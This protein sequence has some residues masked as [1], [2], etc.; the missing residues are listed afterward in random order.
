MPKQTRNRLA[1]VLFHL[2]GVLVTLACLLP[3]YWVVVASLRA[4]GLPPA[5]GIEWWPAAAHW[6][7]YAELFRSLPMARYLLNSLI[8]VLSAVPLT[9]LVA[10]LAGFGLSQLGNLWRRR[11]VAVS[12]ALLLVPG[13]A[14]WTLR[15]YVLNALGLIDSLG[16]LIVPALAGGSPLFI[17]LFYW[18]CWR[19]PPELYEFAR[20]EGAGAWTVW[21]H[22]ARPLIWPTTAAVAVLAFA[23]YWGDFTTPVLYIFRPDLYTLPVGLRLVQQMD[24]SNL[25]LL[26]AGSVLMIAPVVVLFLALQRRFLNDLSLGGV[27]DVN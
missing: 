25:P 26:M 9:M 21:W 3:L 17:L 2:A 8:V 6:D 5:R 19:I 4:P 14:I 15:F 7:N 27:T 18:A 13:M 22:V 11:L 16:A 24:A 20:L 12:V 10:A 23:L 1:G